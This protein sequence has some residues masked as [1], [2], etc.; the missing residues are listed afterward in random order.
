MVA[1]HTARPVR[2]HL[3]RTFRERWIGREGPISW[4]P[5]S[6]VLT[7]CDYFLWG[8]VK[9]QVYLTRPLTADDLRDRIR[10][11]FASI[12]PNMMR[13]VINDFQVHLKI[14]MY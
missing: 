9:Q 6:P 3:N 8:Y 13:N 2:A 12:S 4:P 7:P 14:C 1:L 11:A 10:E 5:G